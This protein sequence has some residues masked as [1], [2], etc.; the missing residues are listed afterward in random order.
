MWSCE[1]ERHAQSASAVLCFTL[2]SATHY[3]LY[4]PFHLVTVYLSPPCLS[5]SIVSHLFPHLPSFPLLPFAS[6]S[7]FSHPPL[8]LHLLSVNFKVPTDSVFCRCVVFYSIW[9][10][11]LSSWWHKVRGR[12]GQTESL[13]SLQGFN[14]WWQKERHTTLT[15][16]FS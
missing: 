11:S 15:F 10:F 12:K 1:A 14:I 9:V 16:G 6:S 8:S 4:P 5:V 2:C 7:F 13:S 3:F